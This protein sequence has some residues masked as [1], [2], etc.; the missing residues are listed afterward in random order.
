MSGN[1]CDSALQTAPIVSDFA[2]ATGSGC[3][4]AAPIDALERLS[5]V[6]IARHGHL[7]GRRR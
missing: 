2:R 4:S 7:S 1:S 6:R 3:A 5:S